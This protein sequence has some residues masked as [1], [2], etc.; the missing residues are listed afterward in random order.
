MA[1]FAGLALLVIA[2]AHSAYAEPDPRLFGTWKLNLV[3]SR[4]VLGPPPLD[5]TL[6]V[7]PAGDGLKVSV[8]T[9]VTADIHIR[10]SYSARIDG[11]ENVIDGE[12]TPNGA[13]TVALVAIDPQTTDVVFRQAMDVVLT[14]RMTLSSDGRV[15]RLSSKGTNRKE[16]P[17][18]S[19]IVLD[20]Q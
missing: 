13:E 11:R 19:D 20:K 17:T 14:T 5:Q 8:E 18:H 9:I 12:L 2:V 4:Y 1:R 6:V 16:Q 3:K 15:L 7:E 10:Y